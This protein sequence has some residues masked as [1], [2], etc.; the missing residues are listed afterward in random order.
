M[1]YR[2]L[3]GALI[4]C[5]LLH[6]LPVSARPARRPARDHLTPEE[7]ELVREAQMLDKR[8]EVFVK[9]IDRRFLVLTDPAAATSKQVQKDAEKWG[10]LPK[11]TRRD[12]L[13]DIAKILEEAINNIDDVA[14]RDDKN[15]LLPKAIRK[16]AEAAGRFQSQLTPMRARIENGDERDQLEQALENIQSILEAA[17]R[18]PP[19]SKKTKG[20]S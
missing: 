6:A 13:W 7:V 12:I 8:I 5:L 1:I 11:G 14:A 17:N 19:P 2:R 15:P 3:S 9:A 18:L 10:Q 20:K 16:L 4:L